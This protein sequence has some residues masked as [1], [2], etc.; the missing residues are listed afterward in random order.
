MQ[1]IINEFRQGH[2]VSRQM[3][4]GRESDR[5]SSDFHSWRSGE[6]PWSA[7]RRN[8]FVPSSRVLFHLQ[9]EAPC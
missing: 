9:T 3:E 6:A 4:R 2:A 1:E 8:R 7:F 5:F